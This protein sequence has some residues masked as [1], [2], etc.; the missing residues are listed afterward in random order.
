MEPDRL[1]DS[2]TCSKWGFQAMHDRRPMR[3]RQ[4]GVTF[5]GWLFLLAPLAIV[6]YAGIRLAPMYL[7]YMKVA[8]ALNEVA[9]EYKTGGANVQGIK[10]TLDRHFEIDMINYPTWQDVKVTHTDG[11]WDVEAA[12]EDKAPLFQ[13]I[14]LYIEFDK[15]VHAND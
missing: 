15:K 2:L 12:Y 5:I 8:K 3:S 9:T 1:G 13:N 14:W 4:R 10:M 11:G 6:V 7:N